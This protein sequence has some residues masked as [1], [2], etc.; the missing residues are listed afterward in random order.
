[1]AFC[2]LLFWANDP[3][4]GD[5]IEIRASWH[6]N[7]AVEQQTAMSMDP[8]LWQAIQRQPTSCKCPPAIDRGTRVG[9]LPHTPRYLPGASSILLSVQTAEQGIRV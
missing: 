1:M 4:L 5:S 8:F 3:R 6:N 2:V 7:S 9:V